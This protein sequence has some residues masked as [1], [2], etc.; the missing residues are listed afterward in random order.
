MK[1]QHL[2]AGTV[3]DVTDVEAAALYQAGR[4]YPAADAPA[5]E[6]EK[7]TKAKK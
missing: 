4:G 5:P 7:A 6:P 1:G 2:S 3:A